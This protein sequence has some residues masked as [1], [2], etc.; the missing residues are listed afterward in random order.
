MRHVIYVQQ[1]WGTQLETRTHI[2][3]Y[4]HTDVQT[5]L[6][7][8][9]HTY[10]HPY[11][12]TCTGVKRHTIGDT[13]THAPIH[14]YRRTDKLTRIHTYIYVGTYV[15]TFKHWRAHKCVMSHISMSH[16]TH[17]N[18]SCHMWKKRVRNECITWR[19]HMAESRH[20]TPMKKSW[21]TPSRAFR[22]LPHNAFQMYM[23]ESCRI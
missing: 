21:R 9:I 12:H 19:M 16:V 1:S 5:N 17:M 7:I 4:T 3:T 10:T 18:E 13:Y 6:H 23:N 20:V 11:I 2:H 22:G 8:Y 14:T 15:H